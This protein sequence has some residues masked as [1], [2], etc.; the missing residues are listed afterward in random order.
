MFAGNQPGDYHVYPDGRVLISGGHSL[1]DPEHGFVGEYNLIW[2]TN[3]GYLDTTRPHRRCNGTIYDIE[4]LPDGKF[5]LSGVFSTYEDQP[6]GRIIR[7]FPDGALD[8]TFHTDIFWGQAV[9]YHVQPDGKFVAA[10]RFLFSGEPDTLHLIRLLPDGQLDT[11]FNNHLRSASAQNGG[12]YPWV[13]I[14]PVSA[15]S[16]IVFGAFRSINE[17]PRGG[18]AVVDTSGQLTTDILSGS[19]CGTWD[20]QGLIKGSISGIVPTSN[21]Q[22]YIWGSYHGYDDGTTN[23]TEQ[24]MVSR[25]YGLDVGVQE[26]DRTT[27][28]LYPNPAATQVTVQLKQVPARGELAVRDALGRVLLRQRTISYYTTLALHG[29]SSGVYMVELWDAEGRI[30]TQRLVVE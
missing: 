19:G 5:L 17:Q 25:L 3:T 18:I 10:G 11:S 24:R 8:T 2:F 21:G 29:A 30:A 13:G 16:W 1:N 12:F 23:D 20:D 22:H 26:R 14:Y 27:F 9:G 4:P 15:T 28:Q 6:V 7:V